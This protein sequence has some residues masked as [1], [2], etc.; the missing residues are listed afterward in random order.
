MSLHSQNLPIYVQH[1][2]IQWDAFDLV[3]NNYPIENDNW[4]IQE[5]NF[6]MLK[7]NSSFDHNYDPW[8]RKLRAWE[9]LDKDGFIVECDAWTMKLTSKIAASLYEIRYT[10]VTGKCI[11]LWRYCDESKYVCVPS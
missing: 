3:N 5:G 2:D 7:E 11:P 1:N 10:T 8:N 6:L 4:E 9:F